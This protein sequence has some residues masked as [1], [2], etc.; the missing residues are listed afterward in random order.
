KRGAFSPSD[1]LLQAPYRDRRPR[2]S[3]SSQ[4]GPFPALDTK[5]PAPG[6]LPNPVSSAASMRR[7]AWR[8]AAGAFLIA[9]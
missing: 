8:G 3:F 6:R 2:I 4:G 5:K 7:G 9:L 1:A